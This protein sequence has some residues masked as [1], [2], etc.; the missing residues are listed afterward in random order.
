MMKALYADVA[1]LNT[2][3]AKAKE[4]NTSFSA[5]ACKYMEEGLARAG[6]APQTPVNGP[7][8]LVGLSRLELAVLNGMKALELRNYEREHGEIL[9]RNVFHT[10][11]EISRAAGRYPS[12]A[13]RGLRE[14]EHRGS[15]VCELRHSLLRAP[16]VLEAPEVEHW[17]RTAAVGPGREIP[18][19]E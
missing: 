5:L 7:P 4:L 13:L 1:L 9:Y 11:K 19:R 15:V 6:A 8:S 17:H 3:T 12:E 16:G 10:L 14:L 2:M 18:T